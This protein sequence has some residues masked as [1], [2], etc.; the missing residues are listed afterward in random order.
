MREWQDLHSAMR[1]LSSWVPPADS[2]TMWCTS[3]AAVTRPSRLHI[4]HRGCAAMNLRRMAGHA[5]LYLFF[6]S[7]VRPWRLYWDVTSFWCA[8]QYCLSVSSGQPV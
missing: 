3:A 4:S 1:L 5:P 8:G 7:G 2:G 6:I